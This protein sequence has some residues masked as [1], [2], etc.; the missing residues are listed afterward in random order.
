MKK[1]A[2]LF[3]CLFSLSTYAQSLEVREINVGSEVEVSTQRL[4]YN[5]GRVWVNSMNIVR[6]WITN[7]GAAPL[8]REGFF[9]RGMFFEAYTDCPRVLAPA[10]RCNLEIRY[11]PAF[12]GFHSGR[13]EMQFIDKNDIIVDVYGNAARM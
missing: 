5:F 7:Q 9:V 1:I 13:V 8:A 3:V 10:Q 2:I 11:W 6:Y 4:S 12:E